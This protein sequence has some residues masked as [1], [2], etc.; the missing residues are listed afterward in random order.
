M[1]DV[2]Y[3]VIFLVLCAATVGLSKACERLAPTEI[4]GKS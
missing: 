1:L 4:G 3:I 2:L